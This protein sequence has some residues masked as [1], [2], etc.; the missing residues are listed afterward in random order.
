[1]ASIQKRGKNY[2]VIYTY[3]DQGGEKRQKWETY[4]SY[5]DAQKRKAEVE[6]EILN[7]S[8]IAPRNLTISAF[9]EEFVAMYGEK[10]WSI[11]IYDSNCSLIKNYINPIIGDL[12]VQSITPHAVDQFIQKLRKTPSVTTKTHKPSRE[13][14]SDRTVEK[15]VKL[16][17]CAYNQAM[18]WEIVPRNPFNG[19]I[20]VRPEYKKRDIWTAGMIRTALDACKD[21]KLYVAMN[22]AFACSMR[23]GEILGLQWSNVHITDDEIERDEAYVYIDRELQRASNT[24]I[25]M[26]G[27]KDV[28]YIFEPT[29]PTAS[30]RL[31]LK[32]PKTDSSVRKVWL[33]QTLARILQEWRKSQNNMRSFLGEEYQDYD[34]VVTL[35]NGRPCEDRI[36]LNSFYKLREEAGL[37]RVVF[38]SLRHS[39]TTYKLKLNHGDLK[40]TQGDTGHAEIDMITKIYAH[41]LDEDRKINAQRFEN[42]FY[43]QPELRGM[44]PVRSERENS[45]ID[46][47]MLIKQLV[48][49][50]ELMNTLASYI[51]AQAFSRP[52]ANN[53]D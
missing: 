17:R 31:I 52:T 12:E 25:E 8:F 13:L 15:V 33:P 39:S 6:L 38:H 41:I 23:M 53:F 1:M 35:P 37:P 42:A 9:M 43:S 22:L 48:Q 40:A 18:R 14:I 7:G 32:K 34:L 26:L 36:I 24:A 28:Y 47:N 19:A 2:A 51:V 30:T 10:K 21:N 27:K 16:M 44:M 45:M 5:K 29:I 49:T 20:T 50:P 3:Q 11:S 4:S 46:P